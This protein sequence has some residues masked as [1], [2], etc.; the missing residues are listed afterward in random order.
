MGHPLELVSAALADQ[1]GGGTAGAV[2]SWGPGFFEQS[3]QFLGY[4]PT[5]LWIISPFTHCRAKISDIEHRS[6][7]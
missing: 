7:T 2:K 6:C 3:M 5:G 4:R 1:I